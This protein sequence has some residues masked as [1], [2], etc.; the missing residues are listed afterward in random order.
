MEVYKRG[1]RD[2]PFKSLAPA[3]ETM[4]GRE[5]GSIDDIVAGEDPGYSREA[6]GEVR[7]HLREFLEHFGLAVAGERALDAVYGER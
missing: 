4:F 1:E 6:E 3:Y 5:P 2:T 7:G